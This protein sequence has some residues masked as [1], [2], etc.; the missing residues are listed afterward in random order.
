MR[1]RLGKSWTEGPNR[2]ELITRHIA[3]RPN[4]RTAINTHSRWLF[5]GVAGQ[6]LKRA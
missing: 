4:M 5:P 2:S 3:T 1:I 6:P